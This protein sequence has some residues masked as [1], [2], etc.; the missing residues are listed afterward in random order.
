MAYFRYL[1]HTDNDCLLSAFTHLLEDAGLNVCSECSNKSQIFAEEITSNGDYKSKVKVLISW[2]NKQLK[3]CFVEVRSD[4]PHLKNGTRC[5][6]I[7]NHLNTLI[8]PK[9]IPSKP[10][11]PS[12]RNSN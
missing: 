4:E 10:I 2:S 3:Q 8:P 6:E 1:S 9:L 7:A 11:Q 12:S 5:E